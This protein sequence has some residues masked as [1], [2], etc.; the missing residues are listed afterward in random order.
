[1]ATRALFHDDPYIRQFEGRVIDARPTG[2][3]L[4]VILDQTAFYAESG[5]QPADRGT[6]A[7]FA[8]KQVFERDGGI[9]HLLDADRGRLEGTVKGIIDWKRR[10]DL[11]Q[12]HC[13]QHI[14]SAAF[15]RLCKAETV[16]FHLTEEHVQID[17]D[18]PEVGKDILDEVENLANRVVWSPARVLIHW[19][20]DDELANMPL[21]KAPARSEGIRVVEVEGFDWS[22]CG[23]T[24]PA[25]A[26]EVGLIKVIRS[27]RAKGHTRIEFLCGSRALNDYRAK[28]RML[29][30]I[31]AAQSI[32]DDQLGEHIERLQESARTMKKSLQEASERLLD[33]EAAELLSK[34]SGNPRVVSATF[35]GRDVDD[36]R[37]LAAHITAHPGTVA[38]LAG[39][40]GGMLQFA[41]ARSTDV[42][43]HMGQLCKTLLPFIDGKGGGSAQSAQGGGQNAGG[44]DAAMHHAREAVSGNEG[45]RS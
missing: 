44:W 7:G 33:Y 26:A 10:Y 21:R 14:L 15:F 28:N 8:V 22:P 24:H 23:G 4:E 3:G 45:F 25:T 37:K 18:M 38:F 20:T 9:V 40:A 43:I 32:K 12:Q 13:G 16:G 2:D 30:E 42:N 17:L 36:L 41:M 5:G 31:A 27:E 11:M 39:I 34:V 29:L 6:L 1:M 35:E 19:P